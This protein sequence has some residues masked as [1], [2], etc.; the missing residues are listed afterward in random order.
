[1]PLSRLK[2]LLPDSVKGMYCVVQN[3]CNQTVTYRIDGGE[4]TYLGEGELQN[5]KY[6]DLA[7]YVDLNLQVHPKAA[8]T[9]GHCM[10]SMKIYPSEDFED[11][12]KTNT[13]IIYASV[14][15]GT[16]V[17]IAITLIIYDR[18]VTKRN[19]K[20]IFQAAKTNAI[21]SKFVPDDLRDRIMGFE[22]RDV[23][24]S[25]RGV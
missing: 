10:Y 1:M 11:D 21:L 25:Y 13:P 7:V 8:S 14:V 20:M 6:D 18:T 9:P 15:A 4:A 22:S 23:E 24:E 5:M 17:L 12:Y 16:F 3:T 19:E 2:N